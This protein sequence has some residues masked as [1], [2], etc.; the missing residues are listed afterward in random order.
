MN[1]SVSVYACRAWPASF[2]C[3]PISCGSKDGVPVQSTP[4]PLRSIKD[5]RSSIIG[6]ETLVRCGPSAFWLRLYISIDFPNPQF[7]KT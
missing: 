7:H 3:Q 5:I 6:A 1:S 2:P 4:H